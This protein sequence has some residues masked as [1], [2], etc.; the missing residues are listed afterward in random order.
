MFDKVA[1][2]RALLTKGL[3]RT[4]ERH[5]TMREVHVGG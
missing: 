2:I 4:S 3:K 1:A 5:T